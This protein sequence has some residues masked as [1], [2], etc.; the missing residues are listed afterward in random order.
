MAVIHRVAGRVLPVNA[1]GEVLL[2]QGQDPAHPGDLHW[3]TIGGAVDGSEPVA[4]AA[5]REM[6]EETGLVVEEGRLVGP[7]HR[8]DYPFSWDGRDYVSDNHFFAIGLAADVEVEFS[9][10]ESGEVGN[11][12]QARWWTPEDL[13]ATGEAAHHDLPAIM[14]TAIAAVRK[15]G[16]PA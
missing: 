1:D 2:L 3:V 11:I 7:I 5:V 10:L 6:R 16:R 8:G 12:L 4:T 13:A 15:E 14:T 9:G